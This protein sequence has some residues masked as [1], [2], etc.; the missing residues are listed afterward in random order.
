MPARVSSIG[1][2]FDRQS[3]SVFSLIFP[4][5]GIRSPDRTRSMHVLGLAEREE[6]SRDLSAQR[7]LRS[8]ASLF[9]RAQWTINLE[10]LRYSARSAYRA[11]TSDQKCLGPGQGDGESR[12]TPSDSLENCA[13]CCIDQLNPPPEDTSASSGIVRKRTLK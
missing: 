3:S 2:A 10:L 1:R 12:A 7:S 9:G 8:I 11:A 4:T 5:G 6:I 13:M